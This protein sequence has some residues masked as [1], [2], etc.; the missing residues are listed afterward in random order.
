MLKKKCEGFWKSINLKYWEMCPSEFKKVKK[1]NFLSH[2]AYLA[3]AKFLY[4]RSNHSCSVIHDDSAL[5]FKQAV[6][7]LN[8]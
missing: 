5:V 2:K 6:H 8:N 7:L 3:M 1:K 4:D